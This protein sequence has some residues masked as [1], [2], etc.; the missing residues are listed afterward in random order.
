MIDG[1]DDRRAGR[2]VAA[3]RVQL[4]LRQDDVGTRAGVDQK[5]I[6]LIETG[7]MD[8]VSVRRFRR[9]CAA[10][11]IDSSIEL[12]WRGGQA[13][14]LIDAGHAAIVEA[15]MN[16]LA[17]AGWD[18]TPEFSFN[19]FGD[20]GSVDILAWHSRSRTLLIVEVKTRLTDLQAMLLSLC[21]KVRV[22]PSEAASRS[23]WHRTGLGTIVVVA[24]T[25]GNR[26]VLREHRAT[27]EAVLPATTAEVK[28]WLRTPTGDL[29]GV[30]FVPLTR[31]SRAAKVVTGR[32]RATHAQSRR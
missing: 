18:T 20:R 3:I 17:E 14:R 30:W 6:S 8:R 31:G 25:H 27:F 13:D 16:L 4:G 23:G 22:V 12:R 9:V 32:V 7:Q 28:R 21:R 15:V 19:V 5:V 10:L 29:A 2:F 1:V 24:A 11:G 26:T